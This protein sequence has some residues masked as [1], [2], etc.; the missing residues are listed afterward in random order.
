MDYFL[1]YLIFVCIFI[2]LSQGYNLVIG[3]TGLLHFGHIAFMAIGAYASSLLMLKAGIAFWLAAPGGMFLAALVG[4]LLAKPT[5]RFRED[6]LAIA[7]VG[8]S[9]TV[10]IIL[11]NWR[12]LTEGALGLD[13]IPKPQFFHYT[14]NTNIRYFFFVL[15]ITIGI[16]LFVYRLVKSPFGRILE[17]IREDEVASTSIGKNVTR[18]KIIILTIGAALAGLAGVLGAHFVAYIDPFVFSLDRM[19][20]ILLIV[21]LGGAG[22]FWGPILGTLILYSL[23]EG[24]RFVPLPE[25]QLGALRWII[26]SLGLIII[27]IYKPTGILGKKLLRKKY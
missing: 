6:Y 17:T 1:N 22:N 16:N 10:R 25:A 18:Y 19:V 20:F 23:F 8:L 2:I 5:V 7:T 11:I 26:Y 3:Y 4:F 9:E 13:K 12:S 21:M 27:M 24:L 15:L 14:V